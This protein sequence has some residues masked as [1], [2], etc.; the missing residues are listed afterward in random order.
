PFGNHLWERHPR[1]DQA[2]GATGAAARNRGEGAAPT[3]QKLQVS[4]WMRFNWVLG[5]PSA[6]LP[7]QGMLGNVLWNSPGRQGLG[8]WRQIWRYG[9]YHEGESA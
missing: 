5:I 3:A 9:G 6:F 8:G 7:A 1:R 4:N 2:S